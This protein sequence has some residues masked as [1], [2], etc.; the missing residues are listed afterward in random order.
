LEIIYLESVDS[1]QKYLINEIKKETLK[2][3]IA[4]VSDIQLAGVGSRNNSWVGINGNL[5]LSFAINMSELPI[6]LPLP[7]SSIYFGF[8]MRETLSSFGSKAYLKWP[9]DLYIDD[10]KIGGVVTNKIKDSLI[11]GIGINFISDSSDFGALDISITREMLLNTFFN[12]LYKKKLWIDIF[13][14]Y[15]IEFEKSKQ[16]KATIN[17]NIVSLEESSINFDGSLNLNGEILYSLR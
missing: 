2:E 14:S 6:D 8:L 12:L 1:T 3:P 7:S 17:G 5:F 4:I 9:N 10:K 15:T 13:K 11:C 16:F